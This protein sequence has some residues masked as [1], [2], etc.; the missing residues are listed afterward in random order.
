MW[1]TSNLNLFRH[2]G[3]LKFP[4]KLSTVNS[5]IQLNRLKRVGLNSRHW[6]H[7]SICA[8]RMLNHCINKQ[9]SREAFGRGWR[10]NI[11]QWSGEGNV[12][13]RVCL[14]VHRG[15]CTRPQLSWTCSNL[16][17]LDLTEQGP[18]QTCWNVFTMKPALSTSRWLA[19]DGNSFL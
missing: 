10:L 5:S 19:L 9:E 6:N 18:S 13:S 11:T 16:F 8:E 12:Y 3:H 1:L 4:N 15:F 7:F 14:S 2:L 17:N